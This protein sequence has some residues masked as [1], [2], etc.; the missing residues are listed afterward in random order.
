MFTGLIERTGTIKSIGKVKNDYELTISSDAEFVSSLKTGDSISADGCCLTCEKTMKDSFKV[1][2]LKE[3][4]EKTIIA[5]YRI[6]AKINLER[7]MR[8]DGRFGGHF[9]SGHVDGKGSVV[10]LRKT[11]EKINLRIKLA[12]KQGKYL[13]ENDSISVN[14][15]SLTI[16]SVYDNEFTLDIIPETIRSTNIDALRRGSFVNVEINQMTKSIYEFLNRR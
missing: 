10:F 11:P 9:V 8:A 5:D 13:I 1:R 6:N 12:G 15:I 14:G 3:S 7:A 4:A 16:K 2:A